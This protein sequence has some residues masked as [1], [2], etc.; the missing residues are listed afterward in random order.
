VSAAPAERGTRRILRPDDGD[1]VGER[2]GVLAHAATAHEVHAAVVRNAEQPRLQWSRAVVR[3]ES[4]VRIK[5]RLAPE[6]HPAE[7][8]AR[9]L[10]VLP[11]DAA[12]RVET[13]AW[14]P[15]RIEAE[16]HT[17]IRASIF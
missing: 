9:L 12:L 1:R 15:R 6:G 2:L 7:L 4:P 17:L 3:L 13:G 16:I 11:S 14:K 5:Q 8:A 10:C